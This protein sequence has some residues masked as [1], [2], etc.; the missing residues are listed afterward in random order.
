M[1]SSTA[2]LR[3]PA[4]TRGFALTRAQAEKISAV[5]GMT[6]TPRMK[7]IVDLPISGE[8]RR[9]LVKAQVRKK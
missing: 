8:E 2:K 9:S 3:Q 7:R 6:L 4:M 5:E 1:K